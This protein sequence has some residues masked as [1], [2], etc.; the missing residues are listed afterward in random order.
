MRS[1]ISKKGK[2]YFLQGLPHCGKSS[3]A[4]NWLNPDSYLW[5]TCEPPCKDGI[6]DKIFTHRKFVDTAKPRVVLGGDDFRQALT[7][8]EFLIEAEGTVMAMIDVAAKALLL[9]GFDVLIDETNTTEA[10]VLRMYKIDID[11]ERILIDT[12]KEV[13]IERAIKANRQYLCGPIERMSKQLDF[14]KENWEQIRDRVR[15]YLINR[16][17][18]DI[19]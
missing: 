1:G 18:D 2:L 3:Y 13:C 12:P 4:N 5:E 8:R 19:I 6:Y 16:R 10:S 14:M 11:A 15:N 7:G 9:R 17:K